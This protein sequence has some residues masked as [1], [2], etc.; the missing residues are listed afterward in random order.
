M[1]DGHGPTVE[2][3]YANFGQDLIALGS[4]IYMFRVG[5][6]QL[7]ALKWPKLI[8]DFKFKM[9]KIVGSHGFHQNG[10]PHGALTTLDGNF[11]S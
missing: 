2:T 10:P 1:A 11:Y 5:P 3:D 6:Y 9:I 7:F 8:L 4:I